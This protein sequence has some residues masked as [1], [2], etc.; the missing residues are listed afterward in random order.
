MLR[1]IIMLWTDHNYA[2]DIN[3]AKD[4]NYAMDGS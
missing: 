3:Y 4:H 1:I 2:K